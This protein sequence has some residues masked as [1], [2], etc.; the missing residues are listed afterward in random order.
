MVESSI[1]TKALTA[2]L[3]GALQRAW[4]LIHTGARWRDEVEYSRLYVL[5]AWKLCGR[6]ETLGLALEAWVDGTAR[7]LGILDAVLDRAAHA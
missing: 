2:A 4:G 1:T 6:V 3:S 5:P 7:R